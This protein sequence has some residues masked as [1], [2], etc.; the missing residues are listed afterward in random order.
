M[1][2]KADDSIETNP[3]ARTLREKLSTPSWILYDFSDTIFSF[4]ILTFYF[5]LWVTKDQGGEDAIFTAALSLSMLLVAV[6][7]PIIGTVSDRMSRRIPLLAFCVLSCVVFTGLIGTLGG[8]SMGLLLFVLANFLYQTG[9]IFYNSLMVNVSSESNRGIISGIGIGAGYIG[10]IVAFI[11]MRPIVDAGGNQ[12]AFVPTALLYLLFALP[13]LLIV[14]D[15]GVGRHLT[16]SLVGD[17]Y[18]QLYLTLRRAR[19]HTN[20]FRFII[21]RLLYMEAVNTVA[22]IYVLYLVNV[23]RFEQNEAQN[24]IFVTLFV[25]TAASFAAGIL[26]SK[27]GAK[28]MV[29]V[30]LAGWAAVIMSASFAVLIPLS[31]AA[32]DWTPQVLGPLA[33]FIVASFASGQWVFWIIAL[34]MGVFWAVPPISDRV[35]LTRIAP[36][37]Q[38]GEF[39]GLFQMT[40][41]LSSVIGPAL[42]TLTTDS[43]CEPWQR[44]LQD[45][46]LHDGGVHRIGVGV[47]VLGA[48]ATRRGRHLAELEWPSPYVTSR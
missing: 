28:I 31:V 2:N 35:F 26:V 38:V 21:C 10:L 32:P 12:S 41:R 34:V 13:L 27:L 4:S 14:K 25:A 43:L 37:G 1:T 36:E 18:R 24:M 3:E 40:G 23:G 20:L 48:R 39:F 15:S 22:S 33:G 19:Q 9:I 7:G 8:L 42:W 16:L 46:T 47:D 45:R 5:P 29:M 6:I 11:V 30:G 17:S 44:P